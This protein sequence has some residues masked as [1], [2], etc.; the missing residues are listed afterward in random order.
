MLAADAL[1]RI[2]PPQLTC[3]VVFTHG[4]LLAGALVAQSPVRVATSSESSSPW[5][6]V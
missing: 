6:V 3:C 1:R 2:T 4:H 5:D